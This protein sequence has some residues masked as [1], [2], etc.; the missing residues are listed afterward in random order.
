M[1][2]TFTTTVK[3]L[4]RTPS[5]ML[6]A[7]A[8]PIIMSTIFLF[9]FSSMTTD[10]SIEAVPV[11]VVDD[12]A[13]KD[14]ALSRAVTALADA[15]DESEPL[16][17]PVE[18]ATPD[19][20][21]ALLA[22]GEVDGVL[23]MGADGSPRLVLSARSQSASTTSQ[24]SVNASVLESV[25]SS[26]A[27][28]EALLER[29]ARERPE[30]LADPVAVARALS[31]GPTV[32]RISL[33][34]STPE[35][36]VRY[37]YALLGMAAM[38]CA[39]LAAVTISRA[40]PNISPIGARRCVAG[41]SRGRQ[42]VGILLG[43]WAVSFACL[44]VAFAYMR[45]VVGIDFAG[46]EALCL[47]GLA[48]ASLLATALGAVVGA[49]PIRAGAPAR[50]GIL[51]AITCLL[52]LFAGLYGEPAMKLADDIARAV[53]VSAWINPAKLVSDVFY[54]LYYYD[55]LAPYLWR[56]L[57]CACF[58]AALLG[59]ATLSFRRQRHEHL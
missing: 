13:W 11:A 3:V 50:M 26:Y 59:L 58:A 45:L 30:A 47:A 37:Y 35:E 20:G 31:L 10:G 7:A 25:V 56:L 53:P 43:S 52:S 19:E 44:V 32:K 55:S 29:I 39:S 15:S 24:D 4:V 23:S 51:T 34:R 12:A 49:L 42:L 54:S 48:V 16:L 57:V 27:Q 46:R 36:T 22:A 33:T 41:T 40:Q 18:V 9:M 38:F 17:D 1:W 8:F 21:A 6:W 28:R 14:S 5:V 2:N